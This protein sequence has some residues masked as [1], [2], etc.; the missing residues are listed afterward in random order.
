MEDQKIDENHLSSSAKDF[1]SKKISCSKCKKEIS[2]GEPYTKLI[3]T[4]EIFCSECDEGLFEGDNFV[5]VK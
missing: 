2:N 5:A 1:I 4:E 3:L